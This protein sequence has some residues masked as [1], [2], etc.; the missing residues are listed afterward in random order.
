MENKQSPPS[1][2]KILRNPDGT[3]AVLEEL[4][5]PA[6][7]MNYTVPPPQHLQPP[8]SLPQSRPPRQPSQKSL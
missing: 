1:Q 4:Q 2:P 6:Q 3:L 7:V 8:Q 5:Q